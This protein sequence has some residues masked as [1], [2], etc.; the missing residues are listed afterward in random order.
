MSVFFLPKTESLERLAGFQ[1]NPGLLLAG[2][3]EGVPRIN[4]AFKVRMPERRRDLT[5]KVLSALDVRRSQP[6]EEWLAFIFENGIWPSSEDLYTYYAL[7]RVNGN[8]EQLS[9]SP[10]HLFAWY[11]YPE[12]AAFINCFVEFGWGFVLYGNRSQLLLHVNHDEQVVIC[13]L[14]SKNDLLEDL[15]GRFLEVTQLK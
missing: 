3:F 11:E 15:K 4:T 5:Q 6:G 1:L 12:M 14:D 10:G 8:T 13:E 9:D 7:R 2:S